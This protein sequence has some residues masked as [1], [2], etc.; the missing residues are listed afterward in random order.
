MRSPKLMRRSSLLA[1][2]L[3]SSTDFGADTTAT[4]YKDTQPQFQTS[5]RCVACHNGLSTAAGEDVSIG[6]DWRTSLMANSSRDPYWQASVRRET[7][8]HSAARSA[9]ED[10][11]TACHMPVARYHAHLNGQ[12]GQVFSHLPLHPDQEKDREAADGVSCSVCHQITS[13]NLGQSESFNGNFI[14][15]GPNPSGVHPEFGPFEIDPGLMQVMRSSTGGFQPTHGD[16]IRTPELCA[17][18]HTLFTQAR[19]ADGRVIGTLPEQVPYQE[20]QHSDFRSQRTCQSCHMPAVGQDVPIT[21]VLG[22]KREGVQ[23]HEFVAANFLMQRLFTRYHDEL[24]LTAQASELSRAAD[25]TIAFLQAQAAKISVSDPKVR[26]G[27]LEAEVAV[28]NLGGHKLPTAYPSRRAWLHVVVRDRDQRPIFESGALHPDGSIEGN[29]N[30]ADPTQY[31]PHYTEIRRAD[32]VQIYESILKDAN[33]NVTTGLLSAVGY[34][35][36]NRLLPSGFDKTTAEPD[37]AVHGEALQDPAFNDRGHRLRYSIELGS[38]PGPFEFEAELLYQPI[39]YRWANNLKPYD[40][41]ESRRFTGYFDAMARSSAVL[42]VRA[43]AMT[44]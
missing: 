39:G 42:I 24:Q 25:R 29:D 3:L 2:L 38:A 6:I 28:E 27:R 19:D 15:A 16:Q 18:C 33:G 21:R 7:L 8:D 35:K 26:G 13:E 43:S 5:D 23:R 44:H 11:C 20:W 40:T 36:D 12:L 22:A 34:L 37:I 32:Q 1:L 17:S 9:I 4:A 30:D 14:V 10:E 31:E 41:D